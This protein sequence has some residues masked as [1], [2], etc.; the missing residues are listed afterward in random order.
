MKKL[1]LAAV[2]AALTVGVAGCATDDP[3]QRA[4]IGAAVGA[5]AG[6]V[7]GHQLDDSSGRWV[8][9]AVG[10]LAGGAVGHYMDNQ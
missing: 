6:A 3:N 8:G 7:I 4:K 9:A 5:V 1:H 10:A 2:C